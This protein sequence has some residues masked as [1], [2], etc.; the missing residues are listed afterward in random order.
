[1]GPPGLR[2]GG[3][4]LAGAVAG[5]AI[6]AGAVCVWWR[7]WAGRPREVAAVGGADADECAR[8]TELL[9]HECQ[10]R[11]AERTGRVNA[12]RQ[13]KELRLVQEAAEAQ[14]LTPSSHGSPGGEGGGSEEPASGAARLAPAATQS[15]VMHPIG[16]LRNGTP[17]QP[18]LVPLARARLQLAPGVPPGCLEG[19][20]QYSH[21][22]VM[23]IFH[24]NTDLHQRAA[25]SK[26]PGQRAPRIKAKIGVPRLNGERM[27]VLATRT[28]HRPNPIGLSV[29]EIISVGKGC[30]V[31]GGADIVDGSPVL[32]VKPYV[33]FCDS[34]PG[35]T[36]PGW[37]QAQADDEPLFVASVSFREG[38]KH[39]LAQAWQR[40]SKRSLYRT[41]QDFIA[42]VAQALSR[43]I[44]SVHQRS[45]GAPDGGA[46]PLYHVVLEGIEVAYRVDA[47]SQVE[48]QG[49]QPVAIAS[50]TS[51]SQN[52]TSMAD[53]P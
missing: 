3:L 35:A 41:A 43:D 27:G 28:P 45:G 39:S 5:G 40:A 50:R 31:V 10:K 23:Y 1:M 30:L 6:S 37:V 42:L 25:H 15:Y 47:D 52:Q 24:C 16:V 11:Q 29:A 21:C 46:A 26:Q 38:A 48:V 22:W 20:E 33:A 14:A 2:D 51:W 4:V 18:L 12:E 49:G 17:R 7:Y 32:D 13:L 9:Q 53:A 34:C 8:L 36:A 44:R 19:L